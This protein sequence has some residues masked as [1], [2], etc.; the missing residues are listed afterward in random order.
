MKFYLD[1]N[2]LIEGKAT[3][4]AHEHYRNF[5]DYP[6]EICQSN[7]YAYGLI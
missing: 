6:Y 2:K 4:A 5:D 3:G 7:P 1:I